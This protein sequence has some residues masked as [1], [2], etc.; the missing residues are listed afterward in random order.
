[1]WTVGR[2]AMLAFRGQ[3]GVASA[4]CVHSLQEAKG[5]FG[6]CNPGAKARRCATASRRPTEFFDADREGL[7]EFSDERYLLQTK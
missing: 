7:I 3:T 2:L 5:Q 4:P 6:T 1:M